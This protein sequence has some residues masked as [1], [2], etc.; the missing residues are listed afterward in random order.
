MPTVRSTSGT[1]AMAPASSGLSPP[2]PNPLAAM[3]RSPP[4]DCET[5]SSI[6]DLSEA[7]NTVNRV[8]TPTP[9]SSAAAVAEV[10]RGLRMALRR[11]SEP[12]TPRV[13]A[14]GR[15]SR[16]LTGEAT[17]GPRVTAPATTSNAPRPARG[18]PPLPDSAEATTVPMPTRV[19]SVPATSRG[20]EASVRSTATSRRA[21]RGGTRL[22]R[23]AGPMPAMSVMVRPTSGAMISEEAFSV[24]PPAGRAKPKAANMAFSPRAM[25]TPTTVPTREAM[26]PTS[27]VSRTI[28]PRT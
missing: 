11:A 26:T 7:A 10:R 24:R 21:A 28:E 17:S 16:L 25:P 4:N 23:T 1:S 15:P 18:R 6:E 2:P 8:T 19:S 12:G 5:L 14:T 13:R 22:P 9:T 27:I 20:R 3:T